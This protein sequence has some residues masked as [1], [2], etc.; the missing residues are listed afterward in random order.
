MAL[1]DRTPPEPLL[2]SDASHPIN[3]HVCILAKGHAPF[4]GCQTCSLKQCAM[5]CVH[6]LAV[7][8][9]LLMHCLRTCWDKRLMHC[10]FVKRVFFPLTSPRSLEIHR[11][12]IQEVTKIIC[13]NMNDL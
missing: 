10:S 13:N 7:T 9:S 8:S 2:L 11:E 1:G 5:C 6:H 3:V 4:T 12:C